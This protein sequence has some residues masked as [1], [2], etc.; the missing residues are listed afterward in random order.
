[1]TPDQQQAFGVLVRETLMAH[2]ELAAPALGQS[3]P[4]PSA[5]PVDIYAGHVQRDLDLIDR[6]AAALFGPQAPGFGPVGQDAALAY[7]KAPDCDDCAAAEAGLRRIARDLRLRITVLDMSADAALAAS[8]GLDMAPS[9]VLPDMIL[10]G[11]MPAI[12]LERYLTR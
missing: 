12:V 9:Y 4:P 11:R 10:R 1:M 7:F 5:A 8:L 6:H 3:R 2:P